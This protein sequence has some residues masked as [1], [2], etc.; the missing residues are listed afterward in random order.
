MSVLN[1]SIC[2]FSLWIHSFG[3][4]IP[5]TVFLFLYYLA[6]LILFAGMTYVPVAQT[7]SCFYSKDKVIGS[8]PRTC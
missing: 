7:V 4:A 1:E 2:L 6:H 3:V 8:I 5:A